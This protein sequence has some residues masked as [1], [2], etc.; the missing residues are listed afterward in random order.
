MRIPISKFD[1]NS[2]ELWAETTDPQISNLINAGYDV[3]LSNSDALY[4]DCGVGNWA[5][6]GPFYC[7]PYKQ[8]RDLYTYDPR[9][10]RAHNKTPLPRYAPHTC[11]PPFFCAVNSREA[12]AAKKRFSPRG[13]LGAAVA[14][15]GPGTVSACKW[16]TIGR[17]IYGKKEKKGKGGVLAQATLNYA[18]TN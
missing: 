13:Q 18:A 11:V 17:G 16:F 3:I 6:E 15:A 10:V 5:D 2:S 9:K 7:D 1:A 14:G 8:W 12:R 4:L